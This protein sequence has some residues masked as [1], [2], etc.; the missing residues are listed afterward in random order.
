MAADFKNLTSRARKAYH[1]WDY[2]SLYRSIHPYCRNIVKSIYDSTIRKYLPR[3][4]GVVNG[5]A[6]WRPRLLDKKVQWPEYEQALISL[7]IE[8]VKPNDDVVI[9]GGGYGVSTVTA[10]R[11][12]G[13]GGSITVYEPV[14]ARHQNIRENIELNQVE[15]DVTIRHASV[16]TPNNTYGNPDGADKIQP[17]QIPFSDVLI[18]D[19]EGAEADI[20]ENLTISPQAIIVETHKDFGTTPKGIA[21]LLSKAGY[22]KT[23]QLLDSSINRTHVLKF[24][25]DK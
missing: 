10:A 4:I 7:I 16:A 21:E 8:T 11:I 24:T 12:A 22:R 6:V 17:S 20:S 14:S 23:D 19:C 18:M 25:L 9:V 2:R 3:K 5:V 13:T 15:C 1:N